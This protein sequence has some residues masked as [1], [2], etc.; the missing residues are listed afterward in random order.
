VIKKLVLEKAE[1]LYHLPTV[2]DDYLPRRTRKKMLGRDVIDLARFTWPDN[3]DGKKSAGTSLPASE[4]DIARLME[5]TAAWYQNYFGVKIKPEK[6]VFL[7]GSIRQVLSLLALSFFNPGDVILVPDPGIWHYRAAAV[8]ASA[9]TLPYHLAENARFKPVLNAFP[10]NLARLAKAMILN[11]PHNPSGSYLNKDD[12]QELLRMAGSA[13]LM[14]ILD[15][16]FSSLIDTPEKT[17][18]YALPGGRKV[19][20][21]L[22]SYAYNFG[23]PLPSFGFAI[24]QPGLIMGLKRLAKTFGYVVT[25]EHI[26]S[27]LE[28]LDRNGDTLDAMRKKFAANREMLDTIC[29]KLRLET[30]R[31][32]TGPFYWAKLPGRKQSR[33]FCR[34]LYLQCGILAVPGVAFGESGEGFIRFSLTADQEA[35]KRAL[36]ATNR[37]FQASRERNAANG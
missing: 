16:A 36:D 22:Y 15:Q 23:A 33:R 11:S 18:L 31:F 29:R 34:T 32:R 19:S 20:L 3:G 21:E 25:N 26:A 6:E 1:R 28:A 2:I 10:A 8:M 30:D 17:S 14:L 5:K 27:G 24:G 37:Y 12:L 13:N 9:E 35:Y 7:G 4:N